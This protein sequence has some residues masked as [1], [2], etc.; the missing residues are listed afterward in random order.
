M[1]FQEA[2][3]GGQDA[4]SLRSFTRKLLADLRALDTMLESGAIESGVRRIGAEQELFL[5]DRDY[6]PAPIAIEMLEKLEADG[7]FTTEVAR[8]NLEFTTDPILFGGDCLRRMEQQM[9]EL[10]AKARHAAHQLEAEVV[11]IGILPTIDISD[12]TLD[13]MTP[14]PRYFALNDATRRLRGKDWQFYIK[15]AD[16]LL[17]HHDSVMVEACNTSFQAH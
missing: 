8:F 11:M 4:E 1:G 12:L 15:G 3:P 2:G 17:I 7:H 9:V 6:R 14:V 16:E 13:N 10:L 5:V